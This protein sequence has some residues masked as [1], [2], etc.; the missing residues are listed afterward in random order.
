VHPV[1]TLTTRSRRFGPLAIE[2]DDR[3]LTPRPWTLLQSRW[4]AELCAD[5]GAGALVELCAGAGHIGLAA[6]VLADRDLVQVEADPVAAGYARANAARAA[7]GDRVEV[8]NARLQAA[9]APG[10]LFP[11]VLAD[12]PYLRTAETLRW[13]D[14]PPAAI[15]GG[16]DGLSVIRA[17]LQVA[18]A[19]LAPG[20][21]LLLQVAGSRQA[22]EVGDLVDGGAARLR[23]AA[24][25][26]VD[27]ERAVQLLRRA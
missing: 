10:E 17:C 27:D 18:A 6:A 25:R 22:R 26:V 19:H 8:R 1:T 14:D 5:A 11:I 9:L 3:V 21:A 7:R 24:V 12:P 20:G 23:A 2:Y 13:P 4:A 15:D 16:P